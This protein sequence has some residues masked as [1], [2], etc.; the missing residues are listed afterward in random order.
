MT[1]WRLPRPQRCWVQA[2]RGTTGGSARSQFGQPPGPL[3]L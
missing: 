3:P 2:L 1:A